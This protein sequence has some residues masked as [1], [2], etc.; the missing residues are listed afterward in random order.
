MRL[1]EK[2]GKN[3]RHGSNIIETAHGFNKKGTGLIIGI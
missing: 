3:K 1:G 2:I